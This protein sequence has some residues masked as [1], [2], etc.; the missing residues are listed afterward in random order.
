MVTLVE[1]TDCIQGHFNRNFLFKMFFVEN[2]HS[3]Y[4][5]EILCLAYVRTGYRAS[6]STIN[7]I[8]SKCEIFHLLNN[9]I[10]MLIK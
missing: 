1:N 5:Y 7:S 3:D 9:S 6:K 4:E 8:N 10:S 2:I